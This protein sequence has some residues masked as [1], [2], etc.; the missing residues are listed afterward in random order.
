MS[1][2]GLRSWYVTFGM[3]ALCVFAVVVAVIIM[4]QFSSRIG[5][6]VADVRDALT[7][8]RAHTAAIPAIGEINV[9]VRQLNTILADTREQLRLLLQVQA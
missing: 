8:I 9:D 4:L 6:Q 7:S 1:A 5:H 2:T 3:G